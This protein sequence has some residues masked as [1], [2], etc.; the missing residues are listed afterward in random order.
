MIQETYRMQIPIFLYKSV[1]DMK[2]KL[3]CLHYRTYMW[4]NK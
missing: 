2:H 1:S 3:I 4:L